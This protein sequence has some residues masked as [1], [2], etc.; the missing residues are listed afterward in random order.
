MD[1]DIVH[2]STRDKMKNGSRRV[3]QKPQSPVRF[4]HARDVNSVCDHTCDVTGLSSGRLETNQC[5]LMHNFV[6]LPNLSIV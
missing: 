4:D 6:Y 5:Y 2:C 3:E 1:W